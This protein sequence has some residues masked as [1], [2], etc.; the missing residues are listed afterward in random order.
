MIRLALLVL[1]AAGGA[2]SLAAEALRAAP[3]RGAVVADEHGRVFFE[4]RAD[5]RAYPASVSKLMTALLVVEDVAAKRYAYETVVTMT[6]DVRKSE[7]SWLDLKAGERMTVR[8]LMFA[9]LVESANDAAIALAINAS[10][11]LE[12]FVARMNARASALGMKATT[13]FSPNGL[14]PNAKLGYP[15]QDYNVSTARDQL[16]LAQE[17]LRHPE[18]RV[19]TSAQKC[20]LIRTPTG[21]RV[22]LVNAV[23]RPPLKTHLADGETVVRQLENHNNIMCKA[24]LQILNPDGLNAVDG[25]KTGYINDGGSSIVLTAARKGRRFIAVVLGSEKTAMRDEN[26][27]RILSD[28]LDAA[29]W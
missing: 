4:D 27:R 29:D 18:L 14:P 12:A 8:D 10:G 11:S 26:A 9:L 20:D 21:Y 25:F 24:K 28:V 16:R 15:W 5:D 23:N 3:Y 22:A 2:L 19:F 1:L 17:L 13:Y 6:D 7:A